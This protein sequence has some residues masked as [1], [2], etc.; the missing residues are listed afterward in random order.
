MQK[1]SNFDW[2]DAR[3]FLAVA[4][5]GQILGAAQRLGISQA[6]LSR[7]MAALEEAVGTRLLDR[8][9]RGSSLTDTGRSLF[10]VAER[11]EAEILGVIEDIGGDEGVSGTVRIGAPDGLGSAF[12]APRLGLIRAAYPDLRIQ[13]VPVARSFSLSER[14][15][16]V[17]I[18]VGRP[19]KGRLRVR[20]LI[21]YTLGLYASNDYLGQRGRPATAHALRTHDLVGYVEDLIYTPELNYG[22]EILSDWSPTVE[23][24]TAI[25]QFEAVRAGAGIGVLHDF[26]AAGAGNL[27]LILPEIQINRSYWTVWHENL[28]SARR[29]QAVVN[30]LDRTVHA[31][32]ALFVRPA[33]HP[34]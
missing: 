32:R 6:K 25:G 17:A 18:M 29:V 5:E 14:E 12:L 7:R 31:E 11:I 20:R 26:M 27:E 19:D 2:D 1:R 15:A 10:A 33:N 3:H 9:T 28:K 24:A 23:V 30:F 34:A 22:S 21:D 16:D 13:L 8:T 4:R